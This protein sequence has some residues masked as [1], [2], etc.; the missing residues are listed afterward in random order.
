M[1]Q[2]KDLLQKNV[3]KDIDLC[4]DVTDYELYETIDRI[5]IEYGKVNYMTMKEKLRLRKDIFNS[6]RRLDILQELIEDTSITEIMVNGPEHIY[7]EREGKI[8][9][10]KKQFDSKQKLE[11]VI[12][13]MVSQSN[14]IVNEACPIVDSRLPDGSRVNI[15][16]AP[17]A[18]EGPIITI[19]KFPEKPITIEHL[20]EL[21]SISTEVAGFLQKLVIAGYN[22]FISGGTGSG[23]TTFLN[24]L[25]NFIP[26]TERIITIEDSAEL[27]IRNIPNLV[28]LEVRTANSEGNNEITIRDLIKT[29]LRMRPDRIIVGEVRD[30][31]AIDMLQALNTGHDGSLSTGHAN[32]PAD[33]LSRLEALVLLGAEMP[34]LAVRKQIASA[35]DIIVHLGRLRDRSRRILEVTEILD[36][37]EGE[38]RLNPIF[39]FEESGEKDGRV[40]GCLVHCNKLCNKDKLKRAGVIINEEN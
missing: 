10:S 12:Q 37:R 25:S 38:I 4:K 18:M 26:S 23:K 27:Q 24:V 20:I 36:C 8:F 6:I 40:T 35:I 11:D 17:V 22:I 28:R 16:L 5:L 7:I 14:R 30:A 2:I 13:Q 19:R 21:K 33:M 9:P 15:V 1:N 34:L 29:S 3:I 31:A 39:T 32:S